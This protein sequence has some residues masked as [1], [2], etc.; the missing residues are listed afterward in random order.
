MPTSSTVQRE[1]NPLTSVPPPLRYDIALLY[2][3]QTNYD[4]DLAITDYTEDEKWEK[5]H[6]IEKSSNGRANAKPRK[7]RLG[8]MT[9]LS[10][11][12]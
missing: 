7:R 6:P 4:L 11:Q 3:Q 8:A 1:A 5:E 2:L 9:G 12:L 10:G